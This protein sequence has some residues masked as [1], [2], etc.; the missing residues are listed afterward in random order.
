QD[1]PNL[2][3]TWEADEEIKLIPA[4]ITITECKNESF[5]IE[6]SSSKQG[7]FLIRPI[8]IAND[9]NDLDDSR[10]FLQLKVAQ[11]RPLIIISML[12]GWTYTFC[13][14]VGDYFQAWTSYRR[15][16]VVGLSIDFLYMNIVGNC[17]YATFNVL[18]FCSKFIEAEYFRRHPFGLNPV[19]PNDVGY[20]VHAVFG[21]LVLIVQCC[22]YHN[23]GNVI[24][25][26]VKLLISGYVLMVSLF[27]AFA[28][29]DQ[30]HWLD[31]LYV[32]SYVKLSTNLI[33]YI[34]Q[35]L[36]N[37]RRKS[38]EGFSIS[39]RLLDLAGGLLSLLQMVLNCWNYDD[40]QSI[41][42]SPQILWWIVL[43][44]AAGGETDA[45]NLSLSLVPQ[46]VVVTFGETAAFS[47]EA[48]GY[49]SSPLDLQLYWP[50]DDAMQ[51]D[52]NQTIF[53][54]E[55]WN[56]H[57]VPLMIEPI[58]QGRFI[59]QPRVEPAGIVDETRLFL[60]IKVAMFKPLI[61]ISLMVGWAYTACWSAGYYPQIWANYRRQSVVGLSFDYLYINIVGHICYVAFNAFLYW[62]SFVEEEYYRRHPFGLNPVI[63]NDIGFA[64]HAVF[65]TGFTIYQCCIYE[66]G[67]NCVSRP[68]KAIIAAYLLIIVVTMGCAMGDVMHWLDFLYI[69]SYIKLSTTMFK[70]FPQAY[71]NYRRKSTKGFE[72][73]NR[74]FDLAGG[75]FSL[76]QM[77]INAWN[78]DD[79]RSIGGDPVKFGLGIFS[80]LFDFV[81]MFQ[82]Y[83]LY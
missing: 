43:G 40:W 71:I 18:L 66:T 31:F 73:S 58:K 68:A 23:G 59:V 17:C 3:V 41:V 27:C 81:F 48:N 14:T 4:I 54:T 37:Y 57:T 44:I 47:I 38:T 11:Y 52:S 1:A 22:I 39:N 62:N 32:L 19:V 72:I 8:I 70:Y 35:V 16:S 24:S 15:K 55:G 79:W 74:L 20:A 36:M 77:V 26:A 5:L 45:Y 83:V 78:F 13:W 63:G 50:Q 10:L 25:T 29:W 65:G 2:T 67:G 80:I 75:L 61:I 69:L 51:M 42:G 82:H 53:F 12:I 49:V 60:L 33:K 34:P 7:R 6:V 64:V 9:A 21:N 28:A 46:S 30:M 56:N 76:L